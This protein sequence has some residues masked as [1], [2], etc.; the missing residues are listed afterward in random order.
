MD[1]K[2]LIELFKKKN[3]NDINHE[4]SAEYF[5]T[6]K[7]FYGDLQDGVADEFNFFV[8][9]LVI[10]DETTLPKGKPSFVSGSGSRYWYSKKGVVRGSN[11][12]GIGVDDCDW[13]LRRKSGHTVYGKPWGRLTF[14]KK[15]VYGFARWE[16]YIFKSRLHNINGKE[17]LATFNNVCG[18]D[19]V[20][21]G[22][23]VYKRS[24]VEA[25]EEVK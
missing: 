5:K 6:A 4:K 3:P 9:T 10:Y 17:V 16:D 23:K 20:K 19:L 13:A 7:E 11:H 12:W 24:L 21:V 22:N 18:E 25:F 14:T 1:Q 15:E 2:K 8:N